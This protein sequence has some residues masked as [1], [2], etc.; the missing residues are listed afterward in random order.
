MAKSRPRHVDPISQ[1]VQLDEAIMAKLP[2]D[3]KVLSVTPSGQ[4]LWVPTI[5]LLVSQKDGQTVQYF[6]KG[7]TGKAGRDTIK[8]SLEA[9]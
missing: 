3:C 2:A 5:K 1:N 9:D 6:K 8:G 7:A 4:S